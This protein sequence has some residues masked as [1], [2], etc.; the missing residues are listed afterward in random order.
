MTETWSFQTVVIILFFFYR[1]GCRGL[2]RFES[3]IRGLSCHIIGRAAIQ[4][5]TEI[6]NEEGVLYVREGRES[7]DFGIYIMY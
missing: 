6:G 4:P 5:A 1:L 3:G 7:R 2:Y